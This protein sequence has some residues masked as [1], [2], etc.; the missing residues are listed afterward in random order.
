MRKPP[1]NRFLIRLLYIFLFHS[2]LHSQVFAQQV[3][4]G[5]LFDE[6]VRSSQLLGKFDSSVSLMVRPVTAAQNNRYGKLLA[7]IRKEDSDAYFNPIP[8]LNNKAGLTVLPIS[9][10][11][12]YNTHH[13]YG[14]NNGA[15]IAARGYQA[16]V[17]AGIFLAAG[18]LEI[19]LQ[20]EWVY[21]ANPAYETNVNY[22]SNTS[23]A[24]QKIFAG[25]SS[26]RL[27]AGVFSM[28]VSSENLWWGPGIHSS[29]LMSNNAPGFVHG[30]FASKKPWRTGIGNFEW[31]LIGAK[32][33]SDKNKAY[34]N[35]NLKPAALPDNWR[36]LNGYVIS[37]QPKW[38]PGLFLGMTRALQ[39]YRKDIDLTSGSFFSKYI[40]VV[41]KPFQ[42]QNAQGDDTLH[43]DQLASFFVRW[44]LPKAHAEFYLEYG[45]NDYNQNVR[46]YLTS[47]THSAAHIAGVKKLFPLKGESYLDMGFEITQM[48]PTP[49]QMI[50]DAGNWYTH[51]E[52]LQGYTQNNEIIGAGAGLG[53]NVV[54]LTAKWIKGWKQLGV[55]IE[56]VE[57]NPFFNTNKWVDLSIGLTPQYKYRNMVF[58]GII[59]YVQ[60]SNYA[61]DYGVDRSNLHTRIGVQYLF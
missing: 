42:K 3:T 1:T 12:E 28:G 46:D 15:M 22:G 55:L 52:I 25:Q 43:T 11:Q 50:R 39:R 34:E 44:I 48:S 23:K 58:T 33:T 8:F 20:P 35:Y 49:D 4:V 29:L 54:S 24:Y 2:F 56:R 59:Q 57:R 30:F 17:S 40:P 36:Y 14:W 27:S 7:L 51:S 37:Y 26:I 16:M 31:Q 6:S 61:W 18:P 19:K 10:I 53:C 47:P 41:I 5:S 60:S 9:I 21:A 45:Y 38:T 13:P 32:I